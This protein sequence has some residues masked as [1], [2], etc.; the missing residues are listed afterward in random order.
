MSQKKQSNNFK[1]SKQTKIYMSFNPKQ[2]RIISEMFM[3]AEI[4][5]INSKQSRLHEREK[6]GTGE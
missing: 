4:A 5:E 2:K 1:M 6:T 3:A